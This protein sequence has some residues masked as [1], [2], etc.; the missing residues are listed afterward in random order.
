MRIS[1][2]KRRQL[3]SQ[4]LLLCHKKDLSSFLHFLLHV[5]KRTWKDNFTLL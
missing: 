5:G 1:Q 2:S 4:H 3:F